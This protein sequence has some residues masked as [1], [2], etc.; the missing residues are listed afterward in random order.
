MQ[1]TKKS[2]LESFSKNEF[3]K[4]QMQNEGFKLKTDRGKEEGNTD[5]STGP[6]ETIGYLN[7]D[8]S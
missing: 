5:F 7:A 4:W 3:C 2:A 1:S 8:K 6:A